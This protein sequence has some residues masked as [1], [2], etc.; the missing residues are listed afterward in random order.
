MTIDRPVSNS[1]QVISIVG[2]TGALGGG[3]ARRW[4]KAGLPVVI[5][6]RS[7]DK[8]AAAAAALKAAFPGASVQGMSNLEAARAGNVVILTV[9]FAQ[10]RATLEGIQPALAGKILV[11]TT[12]PLVPPKV[13]RVQLPK[14]GSAALIAQQLAGDDVSV[15]AA[16]HNVSADSLHTDEDLD[17]DVLV[18]GN[19]VEA[20]AV[21]VALARAAGLRAWHAGPLENAAAAEALTSVLIFMNKRYGGVH[22]GLRITGIPDDAA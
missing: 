7:V 18:M 20:R 21:V 19:K 2:G 12:V 8:A 13:A 3:L 4:A 9:P 10:Q 15:V 22:T 1:S 16:F 17:C 11:D 5:G 6:S 14:E